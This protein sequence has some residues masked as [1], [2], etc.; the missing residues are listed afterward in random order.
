MNR[1]ASSDGFVVPYVLVL[2]GVLSVVSLFA[3]ERL[4]R[5]TEIVRQLDARARTETA[6]A[7]IEAETLF[8]LLAASPLREGFDLPGR[9][10][11]ADAILYGQVQGP[12]PGPD[13]PQT[14]VPDGQWR[15]ARDG[16]VAAQDAGGLLPLNTALPSSVVA[17][18]VELGYPAREARIAAAKL[19]DYVDADSNRR[20]SGAE[21]AQYRQAD[22]PEPTNRPLRSFDEL[23]R[24]I[25]WDAVLDV[26]DPAV[27]ASFTTLDP[28]QAGIRAAYAPTRLRQTLA[29][30]TDATV[31][32]TNDEFA[33]ITTAPG[34]RTRFLMVVPDPDQP[35]LSIIEVD[36]RAGALDAP[37]RTRRI[38]SRAL[39]P[40]ELSR[41]QSAWESSHRFTYA[42]PGP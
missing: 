34:D 37:F 39:R 35:R 4:S 13:S 24:V 18:L 31:S 36:R 10:D 19:A 7:S 17:L 14:W 27:L 38:A 23:H 28:A 41:Y 26:I 33:D 15:I 9:F 32:V 16:A 6:I 40:G 11:P 25:G 42:T 2:I 20:S 29:I 12:L 5:N 22:L 21:A 8:T 3:M 1:R 30:G